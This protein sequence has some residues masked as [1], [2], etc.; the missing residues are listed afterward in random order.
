VA[1][2]NV[3]RYDAIQRHAA[4]LEQRVEE[5]TTE[6]Q[7]SNAELEQFAYV[8]SHDLQEPLRKVVGYT[9]LLGKRY[10]GKL[11]AD[12]DEFITYAVDAARRMQQLIQDLLTYS[13]VG[14]QG[15]ELALVDCE[16]ILAQALRNLQVLI[17]ENGALITHDPLPMVTADA[18]QFVQ[19]FQNLIGN[20]IKF[21]GDQPPHVHV[22]VARQDHDW[23]FSVR[24]NGIG[25]DPQYA[26]RIF[27]MFQRLHS[28]SAYP[29]TG[30]GLAVCQKIVQR[31]G[32]RIW[33]ESQLGEGA[34][35]AFAIPE[36]THAA[37]ETPSTAGERHS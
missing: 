6:L 21:H 17:Q 24:D 28:R 1:Y 32:G 31:H 11:D 19:L 16:V 10:V 30:I 33:V 22:A 4:E 35:F 36:S 37:P 29:G 3:L 25:I 14:R 23:I 7:R 26:E 9:Q 5:R 15:K 13:R 18:G 8:A 34:T 2:E 20:A 12:A 27:L